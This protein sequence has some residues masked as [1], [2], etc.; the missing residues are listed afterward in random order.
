MEKAEPSTL[1]EILRWRALHQPDRLAYTFLLDGETE[2]V[3]LTYAEL[4]RRARA[5]AA[6][7]KIREASQGR[8]LLVYPPGLEFIAAF[9]GCLYAGVVAIPM[10]PP[11][12]PRLDRS[13]PKLRAIANDAEPVVALTSSAL[14]PLTE[15]I[16]AQAPELQALPWLATDTVD[17]R[18]AEQWQ[19]PA[20][21]STSLAFLQYTSGSTAAPRGV[22]I[23]HGNLLHNSALIQQC[24][25]HTAE[26]RGVI[27]LPSYHDMGLIG[28]ILQPLYAGFPV[29]LLSP[30]AILQRPLRWLQAISRTRGSTSGGPPFAYDLC[31][32]KI[33]PEQ[34]ASLNLSSWDVAFLGA[35]PVRY[36]TLERFAA[37]F[38]PCGFRRE[39]F[40]PCYGL[41]EATLLASG[42]LKAAP[43]VI[44]TVQNAA[45]EHDRVVA[46][47]K[48]EDGAKTLV[49]CGHSLRDQEIVIANPETLSRRSPDEVGEIW[50]AGPSIAQGY[51]NRPEETERTFQAHLTETGEGPFLRTGDLGFLKDGELFV[52][53]RIKDLIIV[54]GHN[55]YPQ[56]IELTVER[57]HPAVRP[58]CCAAF[59]VDIDG[60]ERLV[61]VAEV[62]R[63]SLDAGA[64]WSEMGALVVARAPGTPEIVQAIR[65]AVAETHELRAHAVLLLKAGTIPKTTSGKIQRHICRSSFLPV[66][67]S[68]AKNLSSAD[69]DS[70]LRSE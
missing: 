16:R 11:H 34:R 42:G 41:A 22:M 40:Y 49:G 46:A 55:H 51:W 6:C 53:G 27:W 50:I 3:H 43:P 39:A 25:E 1:V 14:L 67:L 5:I 30:V 35:E 68:E 70:S 28:G 17:S 20:L 33:T 66:I 18:L 56:D 2:E 19:Q 37:A 23:S 13:L 57:S 8:A 24:F 26:S 54:A 38:A 15:S 69:G 44:F 31:V 58:G 12:S 63:R 32:R 52:T 4:D 60:E 10:N 36:E 29:T 65:R 47:P 48:E 9:F 61:I 7:L 45:L 64:G 62:E 21:D 59:S